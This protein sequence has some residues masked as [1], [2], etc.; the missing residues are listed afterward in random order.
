MTP[1]SDPPCSTFLSPHTLTVILAPPHPGAHVHVG[2]LLQLSE[3]P[4]VQ[5]SFTSYQVLLLIVTSRIGRRPFSQENQAG[6]CNMLQTAS[7]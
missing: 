4:F 2:H 7:Y 1:R 5:K 3:T 6:V